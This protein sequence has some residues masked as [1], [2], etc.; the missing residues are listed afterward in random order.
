MDLMDWQYDT[1][2][3]FLDLP[4]ELRNEIYE[5]YL[6]DSNNDQHH[7]EIS[8]WKTLAP[9][10]A[11]TAVSTQIRSESLGYF[12]SAFLDFF[13]NHGWYLDLAIR[14]RDYGLRE[15]ILYTLHSLPKSVC[16]R[17]LQ[18]SIKSFRCHRRGWGYP[19]IMSVSVSETTGK[20]EWSFRILNNPNRVAVLLLQAWVDRLNPRATAHGISLTTG[21]SKDL[22]VGNCAQVVVGKLG[23][24][25]NLFDDLAQF[26]VD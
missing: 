9:D 17:E 15:R 10:P 19:V 26:F 5:F 18:F 24:N 6:S 12:T 14:L 3:R 11:I 13:K 22:N 21:F 4:P 1:T 8:N 2:F 25:D 16:I 20:P 7:L 23:K